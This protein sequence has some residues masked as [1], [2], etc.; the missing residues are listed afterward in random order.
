MEYM[1]RKYVS[2]V[3]NIKIADIGSFD[4]NGTYKPLIASNHFYCGI[5]IRAGKNVDVVVDEQYKWDNIESDYFDII[6]SGSCLEH[7]K[8]PWLLFETLE[9]ILKPDGLMLIVVP[10]TEVEHKYPVDCWRI[11]PDGLRVLFEDVAKLKVVE[12]GI[13]ER[14]TFGVAQKKERIGSKSEHR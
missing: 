4:V 10:N 8:H 13:K 11:F 9:R 5:D 2:P 3:G 14:D 1:L 6:I 12:L 7:V